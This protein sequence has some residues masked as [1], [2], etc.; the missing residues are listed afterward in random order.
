MGVK[1][2]LKLSAKR[3][4]CSQFVLML[5]LFYFFGTVRSPRVRA[6]EPEVR[7]SRT[8]LF[9]RTYFSKRPRL[10]EEGEAFRALLWFVGE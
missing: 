9:R 2:M 10:E 5:L 7:L 4:F 1:C 6:A 8:F 3:V